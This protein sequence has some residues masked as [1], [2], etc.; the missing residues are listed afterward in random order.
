M[1]Y[2][3]GGLDKTQPYE[4]DILGYL[5]KQ[6]SA[7]VTFN[8]GSSPD[9]GFAAAPSEAD[10]A[11]LLSSKD[12]LSGN[13]PL[14]SGTVSYDLIYIDLGALYQIHKIQWRARIYLY[15]TGSNLLKWEMSPDGSTWVTIAP[16]NIADADNA[17]FAYPTMPGKIR[18][19][20]VRGYSSNAT[21]R[22]FYWGR[23]ALWGDARAV[24]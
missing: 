4:I 8:D 7:T 21:N 16:L 2:V 19:I 10:K 6:G 14:K 24:N 3:Y 22:D 1:G 12:D 15:G 11:I 18:Y 13:N 20:R 23:L 9:G 5:V 17:Y